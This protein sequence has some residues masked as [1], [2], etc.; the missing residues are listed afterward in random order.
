MMQLLTKKNIAI[1]LLFIIALAVRFWYI[2]DTNFIDPIKADAQKYFILALN[3]YYNGTYSW[4]AGASPSPTA[5]VAPGYPFFVL[6]NFFVFPS[7]KGIFYFVLSVQAFLG[8]LTVC[9]VFSISTRILPYAWSIFFGAVMVF[10]PHHI[11]FS[12]YLLTETLFTFL[13][14]FCVYAMVRAC[15]TEKVVWWLLVGILSGAAALTRPAAL[16]FLPVM[17]GVLIFFRVVMLRHA[18]LALMMLVLTVLPWHLWSSKTLAKYPQ[19][20][21]YA[22]AAL[23]FGSYPDFIYKSPERVGYP[24]TEDDEY[25]YMSLSISNGVGVI[26]RRAAEEPWRYLRWYVVGKPITYWSWDMKEDLGGP[27]IY[28]VGHNFWQDTSAGRAGLALS[29]AIHPLLVIAGMLAILGALLVHRTNIEIRHANKPVFLMASG[30]VVYFT[31]IHV[32]LA[33]WPR[34][35]VPFWPYTY[36]LGMVGIYQCFNFLEILRARSSDK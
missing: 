33:A 26:A 18:A 5:S 31:G 35:A 27:Y 9:L 17:L 16:L 30:T 3:L 7:L 20:T 12:G 8:A 1:V 21:N 36:L 19:S 11:V 28:R 14:A 32:V 13:F 4:H 10:L 24:Y 23:A 34:Y 29:R 2:H 22:A 15:E 6:A 25:D